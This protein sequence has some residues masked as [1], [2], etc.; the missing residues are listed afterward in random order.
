MEYGSETEDSNPYTEIDTN[1]KQVVIEEI[2]DTNP[3]LAGNVTNDQAI[4]YHLQE[5]DENTTEYTE[6]EH[7]EQIEGHQQI[8]A[9][10]GELNQDVAEAMFAQNEGMVHENYTLEI[11]EDQEDV[12]A[13]MT[14]EGGLVL[15]Q[16][17]SA[18]EVT[19]Q[20]HEDDQDEMNNLPNLQENQKVLYRCQYCHLT[21]EDYGEI[22]RHIKKEH[23]T[24]FKK[25]YKC[26]HCEYSPKK[27][28]TA[29][30]LK[31]HINNMH[32]NE[33][34]LHCLHCKF[35]TARANNLKRHLRNEHTLLNCPQ[36]NYKGTQEELTQHITTS[37]EKN[38]ILRCVSCPFQCAFPGEMRQHVSNMHSKINYFKCS[39][40]NFKSPKSAKLRLHVFNKHKDE[41]FYI[42]NDCGFRTLEQ[43]ELKQHMNEAHEREDTQ[44][45][46]HFCEFQ[47][48]RPD[49]LKDHI[50][51]SHTDDV[52]V[53]REICPNKCRYC[54]FLALTPWHLKQHEY[55]KHLVN[56]E[57]EEK[58]EYQCPY[59]EQTS[60]KPWLLKLHI[61]GTHR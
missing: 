4:E 48:P 39:R 17:S 10:E 56:N 60:H 32:D 45:R 61:D 51:T 27:F 35:T 16:D 25:Q 3:E 18:D 31:K 24:Y 41:I 53:P 55:N 7:V 21:M 59:C 13:E 52:E 43:A 28:S 33:I 34:F 30:Q 14:D 44:Y 37:H 57:D 40:C 11:I 8:I 38:N 23:T 58:E 47:A 22:V 5:F 19:M 49:D 1:P 54:D 20:Q 36:C 12:H 9:H 50:A 42:C 46:C 6:S 26:P 15:Q 29:S 2:Y